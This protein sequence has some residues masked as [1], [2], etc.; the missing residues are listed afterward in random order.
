M[1]YTVLHPCAGREVGDKITAGI[2][3]ESDAAYLLQ[4][5]AIEADES[6]ETAPKRARK[7]TNET[8]V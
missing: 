5:G 1:I 7:V 3:S 6:A 4:I 2:L 8:E